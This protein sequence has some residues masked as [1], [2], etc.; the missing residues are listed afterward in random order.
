MGDGN[1][2]PLG[3]SLVSLCVEEGHL[4]LLDTEV[5]R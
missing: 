1:W 4:H 2:M 3:G 5:T